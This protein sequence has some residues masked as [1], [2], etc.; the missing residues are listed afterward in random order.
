MYFCKIVSNIGPIIRIMG[1]NAS[2]TYKM[3]I[4][5]L[6]APNGQYT[7]STPGNLDEAT[8]PNSVAA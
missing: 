8:T 4:G 1:K 6:N 5:T 3:L 2:W 7:H